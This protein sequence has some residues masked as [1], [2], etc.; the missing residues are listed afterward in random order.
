[1]IQVP[2]VLVEIDVEKLL[3]S[4]GGEGSA[5]NSPVLFKIHTALMTNWIAI[6]TDLFT[7][8]KYLIVLQCRLNFTSRND[9]ESAEVPRM[10]SVLI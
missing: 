10:R 8:L 5:A 4:R 9:T 3:E 1:M 7:K 6:K 2:D